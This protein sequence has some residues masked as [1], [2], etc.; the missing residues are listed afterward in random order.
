[1]LRRTIA[2][3]QD[4]DDA[5]AAESIGDG[6]EERKNGDTSKLTEDLARDDAVVGCVE[7]T[8]VDGIAPMCVE[9]RGEHNEVGTE[10]LEFG[11]DSR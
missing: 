11:E 2:T 4:R 1:M 7:T 3:F 8:K 6:C 5:A 10:S 9:A